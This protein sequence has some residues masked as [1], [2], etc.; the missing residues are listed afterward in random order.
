MENQ[1]RSWRQLNIH[2]LQWNHRQVLQ[3]HLH[4][5]QGLGNWIPPKVKHCIRT[6][7]AYF[8]ALFVYIVVWIASVPNFLK[9]F[10]LPSP[11]AFLVF[12]R[13]LHAMGV[14]DLAIEAAMK[15]EA[16]DQTYHIIDIVQSNME[17]KL[18]IH[19]KSRM[20]DTTSTYP[21]GVERV[22]KQ[23]SGR[24][25]RTLVTVSM[26]KSGGSPRLVERTILKANH[27][28]TVTRTLVGENG[29]QMNCVQVL[30]TPVTVV[31]TRRW[32]IRASTPHETDDGT[33]FLKEMAAMGQH[34][35]VCCLCCDKKCRCTCSATPGDQ[36]WINF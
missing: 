24:E 9:N 31:V 18:I 30:R 12:P 8:D 16:E 21:I 23:K 3:L 4:I 15:A 27:T 36:D 28:F 29:G 33:D 34:V 14:S 7:V 5:L 11:F 25:H 6:L 10:P 2:M 19:R 26:D 22:L 13:Y 20:A 32:F 35:S 17:Q 1:Q